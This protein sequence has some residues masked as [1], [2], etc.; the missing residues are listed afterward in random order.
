MEDEEDEKKRAKNKN[1]QVGRTSCDVYFVYL[2]GFMF[3][4]HKAIKKA[5]KKFEG[6]SMYV[7]DDEANPYGEQEVHSMLYS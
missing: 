4:L 5:L 3:L 2:C 6:E 7:S 1:S